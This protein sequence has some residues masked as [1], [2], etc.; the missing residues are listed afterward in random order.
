MLTH[1]ADTQML[2][3]DHIQKIG[4]MNIEVQQFPSNNSFK[5]LMM[6]ILVKTYSVIFEETFN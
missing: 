1:V 5:Y 3:W 6:T 4:T 2:R